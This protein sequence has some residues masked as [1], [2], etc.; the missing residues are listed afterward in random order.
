MDRR[1]ALALALPLA[2]CS[3]A[4]G[5]RVGAKNFVE[6]DILGS[7][8]AESIRRHTTLRPELRLRLGGSLIA[9]QALLSKQLDLYPEYSGTALT[10]N[11]KL[12]LPAASQDLNTLLAR[13]YLERHQIVWGWPFGFSNTFAMVIRNQSSSVESLSQAVASQ[14]WRLGVGFEFEQRADG[15]PA[16][17]QT[18]PLKLQGSLVTMDLGLLF[19]A[20]DANQ[21][22]MIAANSTDPQ[23]ASGRFRVLEDDK[24][25]F[26]PYDAC[27]AVRQEALAQFPTL[28]SALAALAGRIDTSTMIRLNAAVALEKRTAESVAN[29]FLN[30]FTR[31]RSAQW[32][33][34]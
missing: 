24:H 19:R 27:V 14:P 26:P 2:G 3:T 32:P 22:D 12:P 34:L 10:A 4:A 6:Q 11:L 25:F 23:L 31:P 17:R 1:Q 21:V 5:P 33:S 8:L 20:L 15:W 9:H 28:R 18:Y 16:F 29:D 13:T 7:L 30:T